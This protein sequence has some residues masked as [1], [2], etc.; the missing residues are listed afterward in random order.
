VH[1]PAFGV[2]MLLS[3]ILALIW[4]RSGER[5]LI[6]DPLI[7]R[8]LL[9]LGV[10]IVGVVSVTNHTAWLT[11]ARNLVIYLV[12]VMLPC[13]SFLATPDRLRKLLGAFVTI[14][15]ISAVWSLVNSITN[16][17]TDAFGPGGWMRD[18]ND[19][20]LVFD[21]AIPYAW[22]LAQMPG[23]TGS[24]RV[25]YL[26]CAI[27]LILTVIV[28][29][30][31]GGFLGLATVFAG[32]FIL[33]PNKIRNLAIALVVGVLVLSQAPPS[34]WD[35]MATI[36][37]TQEASANERLYSWGLAWRMF[38][39]YPILGVG[40][41]NFP[42]RV[43]E[44]QISDPDFNPREHINLGGREAHSVYFTFLAEVGLTGF[45][46]FLSIVIAIW[47]RMGATLQLV[48]DKL[49]E[50]AALTTYLIGRANQISLAAFLV[51]AAFL[52]VGFFPPFWYLIGFVIALSRAS[53]QF[54]GDASTSRHV[55]LKK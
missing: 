21:M 19:V 4:V 28:T 42:W 53:Q 52:S 35:R 30:S 31:R 18:N 7:K 14:N 5:S 8:V 9:F 29:Q 27:I 20:A 45:L 23:T 47:Q 2:P 15:T 24:K 22:F 50:P 11:A 46:V 48:G 54:R 43:V 55:F 39:D 3:L 51:A 10:V 12:A 6:D 16:T 33:S 32:V 25:F 41:S 49:T 37:D 44:Y 38:K 26:G 1:V 36:N 17:N 40:A 34:F 13:S